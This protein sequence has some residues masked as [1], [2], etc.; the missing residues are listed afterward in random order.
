MKLFQALAKYRGLLSKL[1]AILRWR[2]KRTRRLLRKTL[3][4]E[5]LEIRIPLAFSITS[6]GGSITLTGDAADDFLVLSVS[7]EGYFRHNISLSGNL[8]SEIDVDGSMAGEQ[9]ILATSVTSITVYGNAGNDT[10]DASLWSGVGLTV[11]GGLGNDTL[12]GSVG[13]D[14]LFG[15]DGDDLLIGNGGRDY[16]YG[17]SGVDSVIDIGKSNVSIGTFWYSA[18]GITSNDHAVEYFTIYMTS[19]NDTLDSRESVANITVYA[20]EGNDVIRTGSGNDSLFG[21]GGDDYL[22]AGI[23]T[24]YFDSGEGFDTILDAGRA[25]VVIDDSYYTAD[26]IQ[27]PSSSTENFIVYLT[28]GDDRFDASAS[29]KPMTV[30]GGAGHDIIKGSV[31]DDKLCL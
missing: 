28:G 14:K 4:I 25:N 8:V 1:T 16:F 24:N 20:G 2:K 17:L 26:G 21:Q 6:S 3:C 29:T 30:Y 27:W 22:E 31:G 11:Y 9:S 19:G 12:K 15:Q 13:N 23:G 5:G 18:D 7:S 10:V